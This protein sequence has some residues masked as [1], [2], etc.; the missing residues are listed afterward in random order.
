[1]HGATI[2]SRVWN[3]SA[4]WLMV[5]ILAACGG[6]NEAASAASPASERTSVV[7]AV[8]P[9]ATPLQVEITPVPPTATVAALPTQ[10]VAHPTWSAVATERP[11]SSSS[12]DRHPLCRIVNSYRSPVP[13]MVSTPDLLTVEEA[14]YC[15]VDHFVDVP[16]TPTLLY[17]AWQRL[18]VGFPEDQLT[19]L[20]LTGMPATDWPIF[21]DKVKEL[22][23]AHTDWAPDYRA[24]IAAMTA[25]LDDRHTYYQ[26]PA[27]FEESRLRRAGRPAYVG[28]G[29]SVARQEG[30]TVVVRV[31]ADGPAA[32]G[33]VMQ[34][35]DLL[36]VNGL[37]V[38]TLPSPALSAALRGMGREDVRLV[39]RHHGTGLPVELVLH[40]R[41]IQP[42]VLTSNLLDGGVGY[43]RLAVFGEGS[44][45]R[46]RGAV[47]ELRQQ[48]ATRIIFD[49]R[50]NGGGSLSELQ[51]IAGNFLDHGSL[52]T[53][54]D[55]GGKTEAI[56]VRGGSE[57]LR[58]PF[59]VLIDRGSASAS[60]VFAGAVQELHAAQVLGEH[61]AGA[62]DGLLAWA[63]DDGSVMNIT[64][65]RISTTSGKRLDR[66]GLSPDI[67]VLPTL[68]DLLAG[69]D[70]QLAVARDVVL[71]NDVGALNR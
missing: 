66:V 10:V 2:G 44:A 40:P 61:S 63:L 9:S 1:V 67:P 50:G 17:A 46:V 64:D 69:R 33:G 22:R 47:Q 15:L 8:A 7:E 71:G 18:A 36:S 32:E 70:V 45:L 55:R 24:A 26:A 34:G 53:L 13:A 4:R 39:L 58:V 28:V 60:E 49:L 43:I 25:S 12:G 16:S 59:V 48:G 19:G 57:Q 23:A 5:A 52:G 41:T 3:Y 38:S 68:D 14:Y 20:P 11:D 42:P 54:T 30:H 29:L 35:D 65:V 31:V 6:A 27:L 62:V 51:S 56:R 37:D 21:R